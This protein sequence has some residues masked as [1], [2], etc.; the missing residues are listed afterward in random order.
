MQYFNTTH[1]T[2][3]VL[4]IIVSVKIRKLGCRRKCIVRHRCPNVPCQYERLFTVPT[5]Y[6]SCI[7]F[8]GVVR[9]L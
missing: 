9:A 6:A 7:V 1:V 5:H 3:K 2:K 4:Q 8:C